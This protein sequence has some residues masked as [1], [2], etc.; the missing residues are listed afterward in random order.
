M[1]EVAPSGRLHG[2]AFVV[3]YIQHTSSSSCPST[4][5]SIISCCP[6]VRPCRSSSPP[7]S[8]PRARLS[9]DSQDPDSGAVAGSVNR[10]VM[11]KA[12][13]ETTSK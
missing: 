3:P 6:A 1:P 11:T 13:L 8:P 12:D 5:L 2:T 7:R 4:A 9:L 10:L